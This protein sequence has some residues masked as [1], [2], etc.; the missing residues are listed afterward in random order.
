FGASAPLAK[1]LLPGTGALPVAALFYLGAGLALLAVGAVRRA[2]PEAA[3]RRADAPILAA[4]ILFGGVLGPVL[5][6]V[7]LAPLS[8]LAGALLVKLEGRFTMLLAVAFFGE[9]LAAREGLAAALVVAG[10][11]ALGLRPS[12]ASGS[13]PGVLAIA[14]A[15][16]CWAVDNNLIARLALR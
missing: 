16:L 3:V 12:T 2:A 10:A 13:L 14:G 6:L 7:G 15:C 4:S 1:L 9:H 5:I 11:A 8:A